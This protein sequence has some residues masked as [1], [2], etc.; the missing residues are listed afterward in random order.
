MAIEGIETME[1]LSFDSLTRLAGE[2]SSRRGSLLRLAATGLFVAPAKPLPASAGE[3]GT[4]EKGR[5][6]KKKRKN[7]NQTQP[8]PQEC[9]PLPVDLCPAQVQ[10]CRDA[11][12]A[13]CDI[14]PNCQARAACCSTL[15]DCDFSGFFSCVL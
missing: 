1:V 11:F 6:K 9:P 2:G 5:S 10:P 13:H 7:K 14:D 15:G 8:A 12:L 3:T 4:Q